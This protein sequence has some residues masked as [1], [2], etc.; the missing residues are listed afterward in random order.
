VDRYRQVSDRVRDRW[1]AQAKA[2]PVR[3]VEV[4]LRFQDKVIVREG[5]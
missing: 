5:R 1:V 2:V 4:D 3:Q